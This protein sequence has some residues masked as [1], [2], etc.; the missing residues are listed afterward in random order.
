L[1]MDTDKEER[2]FMVQQPA[3]RLN[4]ANC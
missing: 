2:V 4:L 3:F 1:R